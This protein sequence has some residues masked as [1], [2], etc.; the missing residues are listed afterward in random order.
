M[1]DNVYR[2]GAVWWGRIWVHGRE[3]RRSLRTAD[4]AAA[5]AAVEVWRREVE[6][7]APA[8]R[9]TYKQAVLHWSEAMTGDEAVKARTRDRYLT[10]LRALD[11]FFSGKT[12]DQIDKRLIGQYVVQRRRKVS[13]ATIR[14]DL[15]ALSSVFRYAVAFGLH[16]ANPAREW[17][18]SVIRERR[19]VQY[20]PT[21]AE[22]EAVAA[23][24]EPGL[25][26]IIRFAAYTGTRLKE[27]AWLERA[28]IRADR[29]EVVL[30]RTKTSRPRVI[31]LRS[32][33]GDA[34]GT[35]TG[36]A[37]HIRSPYLFWHGDG[38]RYE[39]PSG[40]FRALIERL[41]RENKGIRRWRFHDLRHT[42]AIRWLEAGGDIY[43]LKDHLGHTSVATTEIYLR[44]INRHGRPA[45]CIGSEPE[46]SDG[47]G[48]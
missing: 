28:M 6:A 29:A 46:R 2:R 45:Q 19:K 35:V 26:G 40:S 1:A 41:C 25:A 24:A 17:D 15:T 36:T 12:L 39:N 22:I 42:F 3:Y 30:T 7:G 11:D 37:R 5:R 21:V 48:G 31:A 10:S 23:A 44:W 8:G 9:V 13:N 4:E 34:T 32:P 20:P 38:A 47:T 33:G 16:D 14:R 43:A 18:R 27:A